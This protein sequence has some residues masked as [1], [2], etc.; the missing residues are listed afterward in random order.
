MQTMIQIETLRPL[1]FVIIIS[2]VLF[3]QHKSPEFTNKLP[4]RKT[5]NTFL[6]LYSILLL[7]IFVPF[8]IVGI[9]NV[10]SDIR[11]EYLRMNSLAFYYQIPLVIIVFDFLIYWQHRFFHIFNPLWKLHKVHHSDTEM[12]FTTG[13]RFHPLEI[14]VSA[15]YKMIFLFLLWPT[16]EIY[17]AYEIILSSMAIYNHGNIKHNERTDFWL[18]KLIVTPAMHFPHHDT[19]NRLMNKNYG[20][21]LSI[22]DKL[23]KTYTEEKVNK[24]G[25]DDVNEKDSLDMNYSLLSPF[26]RKTK[27]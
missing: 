7:R 8:T 13:F 17:I 18:R 20:N 16:P 19:S 26:K 25:V 27:E 10:L 1:A 4:K 24:F 15:L 22:W 5:T 9:L 3:L 23:F 21:F 6:L 11:P 2:L 12:D 14:I